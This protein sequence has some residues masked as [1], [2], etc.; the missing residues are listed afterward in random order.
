[1]P[2]AL[3]VDSNVDDYRA[4]LHHVAGNEAGSA[5]RC[6]K[7]ISA[8]A[9]LLEILRAGVADGHG[10]VFVQKQHRHRLANYVGAAYNYALLAGN[11]H[12]GAV[13]KLHAACGRAGQE[14]VFSYHYLADVRS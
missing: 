7:D 9:D 10:S 4:G 3:P 6:N 12:A 1:M 2:S 14:R 5:Y 13:D 8:C 11:V